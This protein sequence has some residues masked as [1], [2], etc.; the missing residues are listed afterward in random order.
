MKVQKI[1]TMMMMMMIVSWRSNNAVFSLC[2]RMSIYKD[3]WMI[4]RYEWMIDR[5]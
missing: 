5:P 3:I 4:D 1:M 2:V